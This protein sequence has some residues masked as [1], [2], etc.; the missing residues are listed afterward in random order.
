MLAPREQSLVID[1]VAHQYAHLGTGMDA[2]SHLSWAP[3]ACGRADSSCHVGTAKSPPFYRCN[4]IK[5]PHSG[6]E[7]S[8]QGI[9]ALF[10][11]IPVE[12]Q[13]LVCNKSEQRKKDDS[14]RRVIGGG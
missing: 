5:F 13:R 14:R 12:I 1:V 6:K 8:L 9:F 10:S 4:Y 11:V 3:P 7:E 2:A